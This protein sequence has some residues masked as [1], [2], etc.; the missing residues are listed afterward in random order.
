MAANFY[1]KTFSY[2]TKYRLYVW[3]IVVVI[4]I[5]GF[6][7]PKMGLLILPM[8]AVIMV[9]GF[10]KGRFWCG[11]ICP[12][13]AFMDIPARK[14][15]KFNEIKKLFKNKYFRLLIL[16]LLM[17]MFTRNTVKAFNAWGS[18][19]FLNKLGMAGVMM[20]AVTT[21]IGLI[22]ALTVNP[23]SWCTFCPMGT[24]QKFLHNI[25]KKIIPRF[26]FN[27]KITMTNPS[28]CVKCGACSR[29]CPMQLSVHDKA[30]NS[31]YQVDHPDCIKCKTCV[32]HCKTGILKFEKEIHPDDYVKPAAKKGFEKRRIIE[33]IISKID[34]LAIG[35]REFTFKSLDN[36]EFNFIPGQFISIK[37][38]NDKNI[39]RAYSISKP[40][41]NKNEVSIT[42]KL[43][44]KGYATPKIFELKEGE[45]ILIE[46]PMGDFTIENDSTNKL[47]V[48]GGIGITPFLSLVKNA[49]K[50]EGKANIN[51][52]YGSNTSDEVLYTQY[53]KEL[54]E[55]HENFNYSVVLLKPDKEWKGHTGYVTD[56]IND[57]NLDNTEAYL[58]G[59]GAMINATVKSL[60]SKGLNDEAI[61]IDLF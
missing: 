46:G 61:H 17:A 42:V 58:C 30:L 22:L 43:D 12:R 56:V 16:I 29:V 6:F 27:K 54:K 55:K 15:G 25:R 18:E 38:D 23:R 4:S 8:F 57:L 31:A 2:I 41:E 20:C 45:K 53:F 26:R 49:L 59:P 33:S 52:L 44:N 10:F 35:V 36:S 21:A 7:Y 39:Y 5:A 24:V 1:M 13:G 37:V 14:I 19:S 3:P 48:A 9:M 40:S 32:N 34:E 50:K 11:N 60:K 51:L 47:F 28:A